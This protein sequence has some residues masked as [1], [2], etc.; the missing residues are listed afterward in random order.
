MKA[1]TWLCAVAFGTVCALAEGP[2]SAHHAF[3]AE[4][5]AAKLITLSGTLTE[6]QW[7]NPH[8][9]MH[10]NVTGE[11]GTVTSWNFELASPNMLMRRGWSRTTLRIGD[12]VTVS[13]YLAK[14]GSHM[15]NARSV[16][17]ADGKMVFAGSSIE[18]EAQK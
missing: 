16:T 5:D 14:D 4:F 10:V 18:N 17:L 3:S 7:T 8:S 6:M 11:D 2:V 1:T 9:H 13:G 12:K 15:A